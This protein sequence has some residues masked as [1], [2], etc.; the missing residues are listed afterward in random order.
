M[1]RRNN[2]SDRKKEPFRKSKSVNR[3][4][5]KKKGSVPE[6]ARKGIV[7][8]S[9]GKNFKIKDSQSE[10]IIDCVLGGTVITP[11][12]NI[13]IA[14]VGDEVDYLPEAKD[15]TKGVI[16]RIGERENKLSR[17]SIKKTD[18][19]Q[20]IAVNLDQIVIFLAAAEPYYKK[21]LLDRYL[22]SA[23]MFRIPVLIVVN[24]IELMDLDFL[25]EDLIAYNNLG[26]QIFFISVEDK[27]NV[28]E[29]I[30]EMIGKRSLVT[31]PSGVGKSSFI[32]ILLRDNVQSTGIVSEKTDK[33]KH[34]TSFV[35]MFDIPEGGEVIDSPG[36]R[37]FGIWDFDKSELQMYFHDFD[38]YR[39][40][41]K[42]I[43]CS[44][45]HEP[46]CRVKQAVEHGEIDPERYNSYLYILESL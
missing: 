31:G 11:Y 20:V 38:D 3:I 23:E 8:M 4:L 39:E 41:C 21:G 18:N 34:T 22:I 24:K 35:R 7:Y 17:Q 44:H 29:L 1:A 15:K 10:D 14:A 33:G 19:E 40:E 13:N 27:I 16:L 6:E 45:T 46:N 12:E 32:N 37:E 5:T 25:I 43:P 36:L 30:N 26:Y 42:F 2:K 9:V 28:K